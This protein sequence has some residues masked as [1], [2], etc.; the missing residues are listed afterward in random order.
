MIHNFF[1]FFLECC[2]RDDDL[3]VEVSASGFTKEMADTFDEV[4]MLLKTFI[5]ISLSFYDFSSSINIYC[6]V[7]LD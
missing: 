3:D 7:F 6:C 1:S 4:I 5:Y 2:R